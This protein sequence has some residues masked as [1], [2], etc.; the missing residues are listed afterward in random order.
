MGGKKDAHYNLSRME[1]LNESRRKE[2]MVEVQKNQHVEEDPAQGC[3]NYPNTE[4]QSYAECDD[5]YMRDKIEEFAPGFNLTPPW[6]TMDLD[7]VTTEPVVIPKA[8]GYV[9]NLAK[10]FKDTI[11]LN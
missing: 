8:Q 11:K 6:L 10:M 9:Q 2:Y 7:K 1:R 3:R 4:L 5:Q